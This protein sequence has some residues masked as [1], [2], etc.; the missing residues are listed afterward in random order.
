MDRTLRAGTIGLSLAWLG[1]VCE[2]KEV[3]D[4]HKA[5]C[6][7]RDAKRMRATAKASFYERSR[8]ERGLA[9]AICDC[10]A[11]MRD[12]DIDELDSIACRPVR[13]AL[14]G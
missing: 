10:E 14:P 11:D 6:S 2:S 7:S 13:L 3:H 4:T 5:L 12:G 1:V 8:L 9:L